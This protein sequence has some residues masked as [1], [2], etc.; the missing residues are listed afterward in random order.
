MTKLMHVNCGTLR[1]PSFPTVV[2]HCL[3]LQDD[4]GVVLIDAG[5]GLLDV[6]QPTDR[7]GTE[8]IEAAGFQL[9]AH[10]T[11]IARLEAMGI[12][13]EQVRHIVL[14][15]ADPDHAGGLADFP[16]ATVHI[17]AEELANLRSGHPR[18]VAAQFDHGPRWQTHDDSESTDWFGI[19]S[20]RLDCTCQAEVLLVPLPGHTAGHCGV[21]IGQD[22]KWLLHVGDA[23]YL[24]AELDDPNHPAGQL[25]AMR[26]DDDNLR[27]SSLGTL[28][29]LRDNHADTIEMI[30][31]HDITEL[32]AE[33]ID[34]D[35]SVPSEPA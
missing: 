17:A 7:L 27:Q 24:K 3:A 25:A 23:Y 9:N 29:R 16:E 14:T 31:Y 10:D 18:Y 2:C 30:G 1:V 11:A 34:W 6:Q 19:P 33:C 22:G 35:E 8:L 32:P 12:S 13:C 4:G 5:I 20:R 26:A 21:A 15:H 28:R